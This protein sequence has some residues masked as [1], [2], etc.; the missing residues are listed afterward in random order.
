VL[1]Q[2]SLKALK[3]AIF[4]IE[5]HDF[6][7]EDGAARY[8]ALKETASAWFHF[9]EFTTGA[10]NPSEIPELHGMNDTDRWLICSEGR[11]RLTSWLRLDP[12]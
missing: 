2:D 12:K 7:F 4:I 10:R 3:D 5:I 8:R 1:N 11:D 9:T 6:L